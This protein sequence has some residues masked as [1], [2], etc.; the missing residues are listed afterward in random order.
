MLCKV[1]SSNCYHFSS[2]CVDQKLSDLIALYRQ[3]NTWIDGKC[4]GVA[5]KILGGVE[6]NLGGVRRNKGEV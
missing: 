2:C 4:M 3:S 1:I 6:N 5:R